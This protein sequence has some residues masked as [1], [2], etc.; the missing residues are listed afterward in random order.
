MVWGG[1]EAYVL[2]GEPAGS[3]LENSLPKRAGCIVSG[4]DLK[5]ARQGACLAGACPSA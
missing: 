5:G 1:V 2:L 3:E 4:L